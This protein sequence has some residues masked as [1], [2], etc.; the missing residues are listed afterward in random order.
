MA[1]LLQSRMRGYDKAV[2]IQ[3]RSADARLPNEPS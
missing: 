3:P 1:F 2:G